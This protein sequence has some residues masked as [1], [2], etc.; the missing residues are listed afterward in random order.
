MQTLS[1]DR[2]VGQSLGNYRV[3]RLLAHGRLSA[4]YLAQN[5]ATG[6]NGAL[7]LF[8][9]PERFSP[10]ARQRFIQRFRKE[11]AALISLQHAHLL[12]IYEYG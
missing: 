9:I 1:V 7:T 8:I 6:T 3:E 2:I 12:P 10:E 11:A 4:V 5:V